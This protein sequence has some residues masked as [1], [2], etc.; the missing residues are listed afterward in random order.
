MQTHRTDYQAV[1]AVGTVLRTFGDA[2]A[3]RK[4]ASANAVTYPGVQIDEVT[5][6]TSRR[7]V[8]RPAPR[9]HTQGREHLKLVSA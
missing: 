3:A 6:T 8:Y 5:V 9:V 2:G 4:W 7:R 1:N